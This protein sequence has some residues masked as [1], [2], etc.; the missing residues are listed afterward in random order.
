MKLLEGDCLK[1]MQEIPDKSIDMILCDLPY[2]TTACKW[3]IVIPFEPLWVQYKRVIKD[4]GAIVLFCNQPFTTDLINSNRA[5]FKYCWVWDKHIPRGF[6]IAK[7]RPMSRH[8]DI[9]VFAC[10]KSNYYP[11]MIERD[12]PV[13]VKNYS[14]QNKVSTNDIGK[15]N[16]S[17]RVFTYTHRN[18][19]TIIQ[20]LWEAN[21]GKQHPSQKPVALLEYLIRTYTNEGETVLDNC[22]GSGSTGVACVNTNRGFI[23]IELDADYFKIAEKRIAEAQAQSKQLELV[24]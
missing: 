6:Q 8:E 2:G 17:E 10:G 21:G 14:K 19:D 15:Y 13:V 16:D 1:L 7:Y 18:P 20:G 24:V 4:N 5:W 22:M 3:D 9:A 12:K 23:G 11:I